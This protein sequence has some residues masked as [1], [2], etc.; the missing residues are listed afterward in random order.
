MS[1]IIR[2][3]APVCLLAGMNTQVHACDAE[4]FIATV[5][6]VAFNFS[7]RGWASMQGQLLSI[8]GNDAL[9]SI[10]GTIYGGDGRTTFALPDARGRTIIGAGRGPGLSDYRLGSKGGS[11]NVTLLISQMPVHSHDATTT[12]SVETSVMVDGQIHASSG[13]STS[14]DPTDKVLATASGTNTMYRSYS[15][16]LPTVAMQADSVQVTMPDAG[17]VSPSANA[18]TAVGF[19]GAGLPHENRSPYL[20]IN[21]IISLQGVYP[22]RS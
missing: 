7:P 17:S 2:Y 21:W 4:P 8:S 1:K 22:S 14:A 9:F 10:L 20:G 6:P 3:F 13:R 18:G 15:A 11:E 12:L 16:S 19:T 5:C